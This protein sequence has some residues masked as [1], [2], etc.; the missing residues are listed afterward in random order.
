MND[1]HKWKPIALFAL[2]KQQPL[3]PQLLCKAVQALT[4]NQERKNNEQ[5]IGERNRKN[6]KGP[7]TL[8]DRLGKA[9]Q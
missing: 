3:R 8:R 9:V 6:D 5:Q 1:D 4:Q 2:P 7:R